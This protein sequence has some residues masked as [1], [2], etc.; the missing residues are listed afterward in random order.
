MKN[1]SDE[2]LE[3]LKVIAFDHQPSS[4]AGKPRVRYMGF[5]SI[6]GGRRL[7]FSV[8][9]IGHDPAEITIRIADAMVIGVPEIS[10]QDAAPMAF[11]KIVKL[12]AT[13]GTLESNE[14]C[15]TDADI[16]QY[17]TSHA[18]SKNRTHEMVPRRRSHFAA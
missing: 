7:R 1:H 4:G 18:S 6:E 10:I 2:S 13:R 12:L 11:E 3:S 14:L 17:L 8:K 9:S 16:E 15:L 5:E